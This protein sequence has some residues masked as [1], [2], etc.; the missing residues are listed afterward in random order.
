[1]EIVRFF[2]DTGAEHP[3]WDERGGLLELEELPL[4]DDLKADLEDWA[5]RAS[6]PGDYLDRPDLLRELVRQG[7]DLFRRTVEELG[8]GYEVAW[9]WVESAGPSS[10]H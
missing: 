5:S 9:A 1:V 7:H 4:S 2:P 10:T 6:W 3:L 8:P